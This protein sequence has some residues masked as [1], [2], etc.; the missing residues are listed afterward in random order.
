MHLAFYDIFFTSRSFMAGG[1]HL[2]ILNRKS[3]VQTIY[4]YIRLATISSYHVPEID[5]R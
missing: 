5:I 4:D 3:V 1:V 2:L